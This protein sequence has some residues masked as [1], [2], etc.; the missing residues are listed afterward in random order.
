MLLLVFSFY[1]YAHSYSQAQ[2]Q[3]LTQ[4]MITYNKQSNFIKE[5]KIPNNMQE[6]GLKGIT[7]DSD[8]NAWFY[9]TTNKTSTII[10]FDPENENFTQYDIAGKTVVD[11]AIINLAGGQLIFDGKRIIIWF[12][13]ART[14]SI[15]KLD[16][17]DGKIEHHQTQVPWELPYPQMTIMYGLLKLRETRY[18]VWV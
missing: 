9:H 14:N 16:T 12:T 15:G 18:Q 5:F 7:V 1:F 11:N 2:N 10:K 6:L 17:R 3:S 8:G 4:D 13:D